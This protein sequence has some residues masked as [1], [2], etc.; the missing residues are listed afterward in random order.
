MAAK[1]VLNVGQCSYDHGNISNALQSRF[2]VE[3]VGAETTDE[4]LTLLRQEDFSLVLVNRIF[5]MD[6]TSGIELIRTLQNEPDLKPTPVMLVS[7]FPE[8]QA[9]A[10]GLGAAPGFGKASVGRPEML[11]RVEPFLK[12]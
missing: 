9:E 7:N 1:R 2:G 11:E 12:N 5:D 6:G 10:V 8:A 3:V 4:A